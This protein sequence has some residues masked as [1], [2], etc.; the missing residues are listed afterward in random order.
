MTK[1]IKKTIKNIGTRDLN[2]DGIDKDTRTV[3]FTFMTELPCGNWGV[4]EIC[5]CKKENVNLTRYYNG[6]MPCLFNHDRDIVIGRINNIEFEDDK[7]KAEMV[8][9]TD[10]ES[11]K[12]YQKVLSGSLKGVSVGYVREQVR[13]IRKGTIFN[14]VAYDTDTD[15][16]ESWQPYEIS[17]VSCPADPNCGV[18]RELNEKGDREP[19]NEEETKVKEIATEEHKTKEVTTEEPKTKEVA[20]EETKTKEVTTEEAKTEE[21]KVDVEE[22]KEKAIKQ[23]RERVTAIN[24]LCREFK[25]SSERQA[26]YIKGE[27]TVDTVRKEILKEMAEKQKALNITVGETDIEKFHKKAIDGLA[28]RYGIIDEKDAVDGANEYRNGSLRAVAE[29]CLENEGEN[30]RSLR[31]KD[32]SEMFD[33]MFGQSRAMGSGQFISV[34]DGFANKVMMKGYQEPK[35]IYRN[36]VTKGSVNDFKPTYEYRLGVDGEPVLMAPESDE[37]KYQEM[38]DERISKTIHT[39]GKAISFT[40]EIFINDDMG[41]VVNAIRQQS[42]GFERLHEKMF[43]D[44][45][46]NNKELFS[47][48]HNNIV[49]TTKDISVK[50]YDEMINLMMTQQDSEGKVYVGVQPKFLI[51]GTWKGKDHA[52][53]L[54][55]TALPGQPNA[56][57]VNVMNGVMQLF[58]TPYIQDNSYIAVA[59]PYEMRGIEYTTLRG[60]DRPF[61]RTVKSNN[62]LGIDFQFWS[63]FG[64]NV[65]D[66]RAF[67]KND[68]TAVK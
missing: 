40:R 16:V 18:G 30:I 68:G 56:G 9:D 10:E 22:V 1:K 5:L 47:A 2:L 41:T 24:D 65:I 67:V 62:H 4:P 26:N 52:T 3:K 34:V 48:K 58:T 32:N 6:V 21:P 31:H 51:S 63:D 64:F 53:L 14:G 59:N 33:I 49:K 13:R 42:A 20:T 36:F 15:I 35:T 23:E 61:S 66:Y 54:N 55:S 8:F 28:L 45:L 19:M 27:V 38:T 60:Q 37:F 17:I 50:A 7:V 46:L 29:E 11:E 43:F 25:V 44:L 12:Y 39:Y 57:V